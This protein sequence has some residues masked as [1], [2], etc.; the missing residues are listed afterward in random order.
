MQVIIGVILGGSVIIVLGYC[1]R[2]FL[3]TAFEKS[4]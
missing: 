2:M 3:K 4:Y 1:S